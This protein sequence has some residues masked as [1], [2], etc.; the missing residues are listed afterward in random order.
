V[1]SK[2]AWYLKDNSHWFRPTYGYH[3]REGLV[4]GHEIT[5]EVRI[6]ERRG[7]YKEE[8]LFLFL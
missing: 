1:A 2:V 3:R 6:R 5:G 4:L 8:I 7:I